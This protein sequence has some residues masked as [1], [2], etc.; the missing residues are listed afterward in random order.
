MLWIR[1]TT[2]L[3]AEE[4]HRI[5]LNEVARI[6]DEMREIMSQVGFEG[7]LE[8]FFEFVLEDDQFYYPNTDEGRQT[9]CG[10]LI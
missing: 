8:E 2:E 4:I 1:T 7:T 3:T 10:N 5:G 6:Q 9:Y